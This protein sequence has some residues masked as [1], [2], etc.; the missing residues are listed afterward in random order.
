MP[1]EE[2][3]DGLFFGFLY[4]SSTARLVLDGTQKGMINFMSPCSLIK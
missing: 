3:A 1:W 4:V 2:G